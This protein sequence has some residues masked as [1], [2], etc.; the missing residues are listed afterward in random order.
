MTKKD[1]AGN[2]TYLLTD[3]SIPNL[4][5]SIDE[6]T[7]YIADGAQWN[8]RPALEKFLGVYNKNKNAFD[9]ILKTLA[10]A[11]SAGQSVESVKKSK[12]LMSN[13]NTTDIMNYFSQV[14]NFETH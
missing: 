8:D 5:R 12:E 3:V 9:P 10:I 2:I 13:P 11:A 6:G 7:V 4:L 14:D 1:E